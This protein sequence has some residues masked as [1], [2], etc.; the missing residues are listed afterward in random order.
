MK[1]VGVVRTNKNNARDNLCCLV[2]VYA[3]V[4]TLIINIFSNIICCNI[5]MYKM[6][7]GN[8]ED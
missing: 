8:V 3:G 6:E 5:R 7:I 4:F 2:A 1:N